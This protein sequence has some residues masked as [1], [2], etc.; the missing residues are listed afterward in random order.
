MSSLSLLAL[1]FLFTF[2]GICLGIIT[3]LIPGIH[4]NTIS[5]MIISSLSVLI[6]FAAQ[7][8]SSFQPSTTEILI[9]ISMLVIGCMV[10]HTFLNFIPATYFGAPEG[11]TA[12]SVLP[13]HRMLLKGRGYE[14]VKASSYGSFAAL[15]LALL[16]ILPARLVMGD[17]INFYDRLV[18]LIP[19]ILFSVVLVLI[20]QEGRSLLDHRPKMVAAGLFLLSGLLGFIVLTPTGLHSLNWTPVEQEGLP[21]T[22]MML[23]PMFTGLF[24]ISNLLVSLMDEPDIPEQMTE[25]VRVKLKKKSQFRGVINGTLSGG[26]VGWLPGITAA[27]AT[28]VTTIFTPRKQSREEKSREFI[29]AVSAVDTSCAIFTLVALFIIMRARSGAMQAVLK[30]NEAHLQEWASIFEVPSLFLL[31]LF[32]VIISGAVAHLLTLSLGKTFA[33]VHKKIE[34]KRLSKG[35]IIFLV[36]LMFA[37]SGPLGLFIGVI[38]TSIGLIPPL[39]GLRRVHLMGCIILPIMLFLLGLDTYLTQLL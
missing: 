29:M 17:P 16:L 36:I 4:V 18:P 21:A 37:L 1:A 19:V 23:F 33:G 8:L 32:S 9:L 26:L 31:L 6:L 20:L 39:Y 10:T 22:S 27:A 25:G 30:L 12:L 35:I 34:Y 28:T 3:G 7:L 15:F 14:A 11:E 38:A 5:F 24:G 13:A 2:M